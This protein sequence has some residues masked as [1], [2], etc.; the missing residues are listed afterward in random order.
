[1]LS[2]CCYVRISWLTCLNFLQTL[3]CYMLLY[4]IC[5]VLL[6][7]C[8]KMPCTIMLDIAMHGNY[9]HYNLSLLT[10]CVRRCWIDPTPASVLV[11]ITTQW[12]SRWVWRGIRTICFCPSCFFSIF[13]MFLNH[14]QP[15]FMGTLTCQ[16]FPGYY[17]TWYFSPFFI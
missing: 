13:S 4:F 9:F 12:W 16:E 10:G 15:G 2:P 8:F 11:W 5:Y 14:F 6:Y 7:Y 3:E 17:Q 1:M